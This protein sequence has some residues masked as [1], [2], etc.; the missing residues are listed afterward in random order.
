MGTTGNFISV[1]A[2]C[3]SDPEKKL[4]HIAREM[5]KKAGIKTIL[6]PS[7]L[8]FHCVNPPQAAG[9]P[10]FS[11]WAGPHA[12]KS[13]ISIHNNAINGYFIGVLLK[14]VGWVRVLR[15]ELQEK[16]SDERTANALSRRDPGKKKHYCWDRRASL[17]NSEIQCWNSRTVA[18]AH[19]SRWRNEHGAVVT[20][21][22]RTIFVYPS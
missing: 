6:M 17:T 1:W 20:C 18:D 9:G 10:G 4:K 5:N 15:F 21:F 22:R 8:S 19:N 14:V 11:C 12:N 7:N 16:L 2:L 3:S 13:A